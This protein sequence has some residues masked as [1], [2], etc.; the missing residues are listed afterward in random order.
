MVGVFLCDGCCEIYD[1]NAWSVMQLPFGEDKGLF[2]M[3]FSCGAAV[4][5]AVYAPGARD[6]YLVKAGRVSLMVLCTG[7]L[8]RNI[9]S[10]SY[11]AKCFG[12]NKWK[13]LNIIARKG[14]LDGN[15]KGQGCRV[16][17]AS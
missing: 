8:D 15:P 7:Q 5:D 4:R 9:L 10:P 1:R 3:A 17:S 13:L 2:V 12:L 11:L 14:C 6:V 16:C